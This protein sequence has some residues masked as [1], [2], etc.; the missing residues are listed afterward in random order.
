MKYYFLKAR[1]LSFYT[2][3]FSPV[4]VHNVQKFK[5]IRLIWAD[6]KMNNINGDYLEFGILKGKSLLH[7]YNCA[8]KLQ[9]K[10]VNFY[11]FDSFEGF[12]IENHDFFTKD[13]FLSNEK[14]VKNAFSKF[15]NVH[16]I[17]GFF[18]QTLKLKKVSE[19]KKISF[20]FIDCDI[21]ESAISIMPFIKDRISI[22]GFVMID[23][24]SAIDKNGNSIY[25]AFIENFNV[26]DDCILYS[27]YSNGKVY[28]FV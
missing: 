3:F 1:L 14:K 13:N 11:G 10:N 12:P 8:K 18:D 28:K 20:V 4:Y 25:K 9:I 5:T 23:D 2:N 16:I 27:T 15:R 26:G 6:I 19:I 24:F 7:S 21:Y 22:G 17:K